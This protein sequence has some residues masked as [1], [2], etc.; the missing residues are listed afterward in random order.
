MLTVNAKNKGN[1]DRVSE[2]R[3]SYDDVFGH[4]LT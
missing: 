4:P 2:F 1:S 3:T